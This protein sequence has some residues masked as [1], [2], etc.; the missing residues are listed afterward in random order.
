MYIHQHLLDVLETTL[1]PNK[2]VIIYGPRRI[3]KT[4]LLEKF[5][6][7]KKDYLL[8]S[9]EDIDVQYYLSVELDYA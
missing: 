7:T 4:T 3:G 5:L 9:G 2:V 8:V 1:C 6:E